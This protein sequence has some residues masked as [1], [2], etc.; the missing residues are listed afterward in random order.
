M[1]RPTWEE[2]HERILRELRAGLR[3]ALLARRAAEAKAP[4]DDEAEADEAARDAA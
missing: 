1:K 2:V 4:P 3:D